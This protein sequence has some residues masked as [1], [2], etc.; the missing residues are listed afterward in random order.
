MKQ[1]NTTLNIV[2]VALFSAMTYVATQII[3][4]PM[5]GA[6]VHCGN[7]M[8]LLSVLLLGYTK[9]AL[10]GG[11]G[12]ALFDVLN[13]YITEAPYFIVES[14]VVGAAAW[15]FFH[16]IFKEKVDKPADLWKIVVTAIATGCAKLF[17][18]QLKNTIVFMYGGSNF[19]VA[20]TAATVKLPASFINVG[21]TIVLV[22]IL[23]LPL[24]KAL[25]KL[26]LR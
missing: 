15:L 16:F 22:T 4:I 26:N 20:F 9:G 17:M 3:H 5:P 7:V 12:L 18:T 2:M 13:G 14:F 11:L 24:D 1:K 6:F 25:S 23:F 8:V 21:V 19:H 10:A